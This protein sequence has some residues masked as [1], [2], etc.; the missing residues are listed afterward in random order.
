MKF[1]IND[2]IINDGF[3]GIEYTITNILDSDHYDFICTKSNNNYLA[4]QGQTYFNIK[5]LDGWKLKNSDQGPKSHPLTKIF[6]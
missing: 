2:V 4:V 3:P 1:K 5:F 6:I